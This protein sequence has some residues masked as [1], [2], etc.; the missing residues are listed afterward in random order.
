MYGIIVVGM[1]IGAIILAIIGVNIDDESIKTVI[2]LLA[3]FLFG[4]FVA[5]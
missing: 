3:L 4:L 1:Y 5:L 2:L